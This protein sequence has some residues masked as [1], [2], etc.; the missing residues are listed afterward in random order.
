MAIGV[1]TVKEFLQDLARKQ[2]TTGLLNAQRFNRL[3]PFV[4]QE[5]I[6]EMKKTMGPRFYSIDEIST[7]KKDKV[8]TVDS[9]TGRFSVP[10]DYMFYDTGFVMGYGQPTEGEYKQ[11]TKPLDLLSNSEWATRK[12]SRFEPPTARRPIA[13]EINGEFELHPKNPY[14]VELTYLKIPDDPFW[15][16]MLSNGRQIY[17]ATNGVLT[18]PNDGSND[19]T[20]F[21]L[22]EFL[23][24]NIIYRMAAIIGIEVMQ[25]DLVQAGLSLQKQ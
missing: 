7:L 16:Y 21:V 12:S 23:L 5:E 3:A 15:N 10:S 9:T 8:V 13:R 24:P 22:P 19:S 6:N 2:Q 18:N 1:N 4:Q 14:R 25:Q 20:D 11:E 17:V